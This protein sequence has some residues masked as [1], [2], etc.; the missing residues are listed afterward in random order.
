MIISAAEDIGLAN[1]N[2]LL[3]AT[4]AFQAVQAIGFPEARIIMAEAAVYLAV[5]AK[6]NSAYAGIGQAL[7]KVKESGD[8]PVP[9][10]L[11]NAPTKLMKSLGYGAEYD[12]SHDHQGNFSSQ[13]YLPQGL[14]G[15][16][17][18]S[19]QSNAAELKAQEKLRHW[20]KNK[21]QY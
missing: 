2:A 20:W 15:T 14:E 12:Y 3:M 10:H 16:K 13:E 17:F 21:Y 18:Y 19:P 7:S 5:S 1:P 6:S 11:R 4:Q 8:L 9:L